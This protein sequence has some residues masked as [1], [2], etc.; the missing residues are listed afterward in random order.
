MIVAFE[1]KLSDKV[2]LTAAN[3]PILVLPLHIF[4]NEEEA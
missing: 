4:R 1:Q 2:Q 3:P